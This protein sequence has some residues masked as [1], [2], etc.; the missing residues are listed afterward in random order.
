MNKDCYKGFNPII[1]FEIFVVFKLFS[2]SPGNL[3]FKFTSEERE[4]SEFFY[5]I[6]I[7]IRF[8]SDFQK[9]EIIRNPGL[10]PGTQ[11]G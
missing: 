6:Y 8:L 11:K 2:N 3:N 4:N 10:L 1:L 7:K 5:L 9:F